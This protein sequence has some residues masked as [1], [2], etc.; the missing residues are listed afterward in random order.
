[1][2]GIVWAGRRVDTP[3]ILYGLP[4]GVKTIVVDVEV[5]GLNP[6]L[7]TF[8]ACFTVLFICLPNSFLVTVNKSGL[9]QEM[10]KSYFGR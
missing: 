9:C 5:L 8:A 3:Y 1:M 4:I 10:P 7:D 2:Q 6:D